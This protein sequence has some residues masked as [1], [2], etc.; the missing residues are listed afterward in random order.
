M[1]ELCMTDYQLNAV[2]TLVS[3]MFEKCETIEDYK[4]AKLAL[5]EICEDCYNERS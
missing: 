1:G 4:A 2:L 3:A 5:S